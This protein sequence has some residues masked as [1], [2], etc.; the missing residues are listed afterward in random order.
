M[1]S[2]HTDE[3]LIVGNLP[4]PDPPSNSKDWHS[5]ITT[6]LRSRSIGKFV[7]AIFPSSDPAA[8][9]DQRVVDLITYA[10][11]VENEMFEYA[12]DKEEYYRLLAEKIY[13]IQKGLQEKQKR[14][15]GEQKETN[16]TMFL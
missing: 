16:E 6:E 1:E 13:K 7:R 15:I 4:P 10:R 8:M 3:H 11:H 12:N 14:R 9:R 5:S 2:G